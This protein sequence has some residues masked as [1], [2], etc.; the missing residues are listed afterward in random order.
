MLLLHHFGNVDV[1]AIRLG[2][3]PLI[4]KEVSIEKEPL[5]L[6]DGFLGANPVIMLHMRDTWSNGFSPM[7][8]VLLLDVIVNVQHEMSSDLRRLALVESAIVC[9]ID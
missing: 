3:V 5:R 8:N 7:T 1:V 2:K 6:I 9:T 4:V